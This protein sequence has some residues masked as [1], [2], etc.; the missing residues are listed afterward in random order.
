MPVPGQELYEATMQR[1]KGS[2]EVTG[3]D[4]S[5]SSAGILRFIVAPDYETKSSYSATLTARDTSVDGSN[6]TTQDITIS[7]NNLNDNSP[8]ITSSASFGADENQTAIT[9]I[10]AVDADGDNI[11]YSVSG[12][13][14]TIGSSSG[15]LVFSSA[16]DYETKSEYIANISVTDNVFSSNQ[17]ISININDVNDPPRTTFINSFSGSENQKTITGSFN[18][19]DDDGDAYT[20]ALGGE[21]ADL[22]NLSSDNIL[23]FISDP[24]YETKNSY[25]LQILAS[26]AEL[27]SA[28]DFLVNVT[29]VL[30][31]VISIDLD[32]TDGTLDSSTS[33]TLQAEIVLDELMDVTKLLVELDCEAITINTSDCGNNF[34]ERVLAEKKSSSLWTINKNLGSAFNAGSDRIF[35]PTIRI[36]TN[37]EYQISANTIG[38]TYTHNI[39]P[40]DISRLNSFKTGQS[41]N[42]N[43][44]TLNFLNPASDNEFGSIM[45]TAGNSYD[46]LVYVESESY[47]PSCNLI[48]DG[49]RVYGLPS[50]DCF[51]ETLQVA[52]SAGSYSYSDGRTISGD[53]EIEVSISLYWGEFA[54]TS[55]AN[56]W[57]PLASYG[58]GLY[59]NETLE[60]AYN[61]RELSAT[62][63]VINPDNPRIIKYTWKLDKGISNSTYDVT[64]AKN[65]STFYFYF[66]ATDYQG[67]SALNVFTHDNFSNN[68]PDDFA[69]NLQ[70]FTIEPVLNESENRLYLDTTVEVNNDN[71]IYND[72]LFGDL[73]NEG[74]YSS[75]IKDIW[76][77]ITYPNCSQQ[78]FYV[79]D[80][81]STQLSADT[82]IFSRSM[83][84]IKNLHLEGNYVV[85]Y[86]NINDASHKENYYARVDMENSFDLF[87]E[88]T[89]G[90]GSAP[91]CPVFSV[92]SSNVNPA[93]VEVFEGTSDIPASIE[94]GA[95]QSSAYE[96]TYAI[97][98]SL[99]LHPNGMFAIDELSGKLSFTDP[100]GYI[101]LECTVG[102]PNCDEDK[103]YSI[104]VR[105]TIDN[106]YTTNTF[107]TTVNLIQDTDF[108]GVRNSEDEDDDG[109]GVNDEDDAFPLDSSESVDT[110]GDGVGN[111]ADEDDDGD[112]VNDDEDSHPL[113]ANISD[114]PVVTSAEYYLE[115]RPT[116]TNGGDITLEG[117]QKDGKT[118]TFSI[119]T[120]PQYGTATLDDSTGALTYTTS[121]VESALDTIIFIA[122]D[123]TYDSVPG[124]LEIDLRSDPLYK[125]SWHLDN[126]GQTNFSDNAG[127]SGADLNVDVY[128]SDD[129]DGT[130]VIV[131]VVDEG[132]EIAHED[133]APNIIAGRSWD[134][135]DND[136]DP[137]N[138]DLDGDHGTSVAGIIAADAFNK[139]GGRGVAPDVGLIG[140]NF[141]KFQCSTCEGLSLGYGDHSGYSQNLNDI[142]DIFNMSY[143]SRDEGSYGYGGISPSSFDLEVMSFGTSSLRDSKGALYVKSSGNGWRHEGSSCGP[144]QESFDNMPCGDSITDDRHSMPYTIVVGALNANDV[145][146]SYS[147]PG[148]ALWVAGYGGEYGSSD[149]AMMTTDQS[150]CLQGYSRNGASTNDFEGGSN[151]ENLD[152]NYTSTFNGT[153]SAA[154][155]VS[156]V[157]ALMLEA[158]NN[159]T[160]RD[161]KHIIA[162]TSYQVDPLKQKTISGITQYSWVT[163]S[164]NYSH[165]PWYGFGRIDASAAI[166]QAK[167][168]IDGTLGIFVDVTNTYV[169]DV[170][171]TSIVFDITSNV[172]N[173]YSFTQTTI[174]ESDFIEFITLSLELDHSVIN[175]IGVTLTSPSGTTLRVITPYSAATLNPSNTSFDIGI[176]GFYGEPMTGDW[177]LSITDY[178]DDSIGGTLKSFTLKT[179]GN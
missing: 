138:S 144:N 63:G 95:D 147:T 94:A 17:E 2:F 177:V 154:P 170:D 139:I 38:E 106:K 82:K 90:D 176:S 79:R 74:L 9:T 66:Y 158:N 169:K 54:K 179:F 146:S 44:S 50:N 108:D 129:I 126:T 123:G 145:R 93:S 20:V 92:R 57:T 24:D 61:G 58:G 55:K 4:L 88:F 69:P 7:I 73:S 122:N 83:P 151:A 133:L 45:D 43:D 153:S 99:L 5:I 27:T 39:Y 125:H 21:D 101:D 104:A 25:N 166:N 36:K 110:D 71:I 22:F 1:M 150:S 8:A 161:V 118:V 10:T 175:D 111:N 81:T 68:N 62:G 115:L 137:T 131:S 15:V 143:G 84:V 121:N 59:K 53:G 116:F 155:T 148:A 142:V 140:S 64:G 113:D 124:T 80:E 60:G 162:G 49:V 86:I 33:P 156:G 28:T 112:G 12:S 98:E 132:L 70:S 103:N 141:L 117:S 165:H 41:M 157:I 100:A 173:E 65:N 152:C 164:A 130:G 14:L 171:D 67:N 96:I 13:D 48:G 34:S 40:D 23:S 114:G 136:N 11:F 120:A 167:T 134:F 35:H 47:G 76:F 174:G 89:I 109:D 85:D 105:A 128:I 91:T 78:T 30:E 46:Y 119:E 77:G 56:I 18:V 16:P 102:N 75:S 87:P 172:Q 19:S 3:S 97:D 178:S 26:D 31:G 163:N 160:W 168:Y 127:T 72:T 52:D 135:I 37:S 107:L 32:I 149:P 29:N 6:L 42:G 159:L 51:V